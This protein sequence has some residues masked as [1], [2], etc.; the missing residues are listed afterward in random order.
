[1]ETVVGWFK[2][3]AV[4]FTVTVYV[5]FCVPTCGRPLQPDSDRI[6]SRPKAKASFRV[7]RREAVQ[8]ASRASIRLRR[9]H[10][11]M[12][13][14]G[15]FGK[16]NSGGAKVRL[17]VLSDPLIVAVP[18]GAGVTDVGVRVQVEPPGAP[19]H[20]PVTAD[21]KPFME[22]TVSV[23]VAVSPALIVTDG[24]EARIEKSG[25]AVVP[26][27]ERAACC[28][29]AVGPVYATLSAACSRELKVGLKVRAMAQ[30]AP[31]A[32]LVVQVVPEAD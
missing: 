32:R 26:V 23:K 31:A 7:V 25:V 13:R 3:P 11:P 28:G 2:A 14:R 15:P 27:P 8:A 9:P 24:G 4:A 29:D 20:A 5:P 16:R 10:T 19:V 18:L 12:G 17:V 1:M 6:A 21:E 22:V 30:F